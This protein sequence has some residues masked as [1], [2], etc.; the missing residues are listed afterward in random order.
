MNHSRLN[1]YHRSAPKN[2]PYQDEKSGETTI[3][4]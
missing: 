4:F 3:Y 1:E 2:V